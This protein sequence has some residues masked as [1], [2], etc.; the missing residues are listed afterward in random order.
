MMDTMF[1]V[2]SNPSG[3]HVETPGFRF[4]VRKTFKLKDG[5]V[6]DNQDRRGKQQQ[7]LQSEPEPFSFQASC[8][9]VAAKEKIYGILVQVSK[10][11]AR[12]CGPTV[13]EPIVP[14]AGASCYPTRRT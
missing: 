6:Y 13:A 9:T 14:A 8:L 2:L 7:R 11:S 5:E 10:Q 3:K 4:W 1:L 12:R